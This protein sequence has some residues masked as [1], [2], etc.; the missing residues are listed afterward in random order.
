MAECKLVCLN[1]R[2]LKN[3]RKRRS[4]FSYL[5]DQKSDFYLPQETH[6]EPRD[7]LIWKSEWRRDIFFSHGSN[8]RKGVCILLNP[9]SAIKI[10][11]CYCDPERI[12][13]TVNLSICN[14]YA[15]NNLSFQLKFA[16]TVKKLLMSRTSLTNLIIGGDWNVTLEAIDK[17]GGIQWK[18][19]V[20]RNQIITLMNELD[21]V[22]TFR[23]KNPNKKCYTYEASARNIKSSC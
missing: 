12:S 2:G 21:L 15:P 18:P 20:Y 5:K 22:D 7:E 10:E 8:H 16:V 19:T 17:K 9:F 4:I 1:V 6:S 14:I 11:S 13:K 23:E 3:Q